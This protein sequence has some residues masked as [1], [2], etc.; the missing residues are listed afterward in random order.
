M[1]NKQLVYL[2]DDKIFIF[3]FFKKTN[4]MQTIHMLLFSDVSIMNGTLSDPSLV[5]LGERNECCFLEPSV[6]FLQ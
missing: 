2:A 3:P 1:Q 4:H 6:S 5:S